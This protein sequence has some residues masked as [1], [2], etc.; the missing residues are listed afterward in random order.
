MRWRKAIEKDLGIQP[1]S[2]YDGRPVYKIVFMC[3]DLAQLEP[4]R[5]A[6]ESDYNFVVQTAFTTDCINGELINRKFDKGLGVRLI[7]EH[8][9]ADIADTIGFGD[10]MNDLERIETV[11][12]AC[13]M[14]NGSPELKAK[15]DIICA[16][17]EA[18]GIAI[19][20]RDLGLI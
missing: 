6:L 12:I 15:C 10:S 13:C 14:E 9:G 7:A 5:E 3:H 17:P 8:Y 11:G 19:T 4:A 18:D 16:P 2:L 20:F 1:M